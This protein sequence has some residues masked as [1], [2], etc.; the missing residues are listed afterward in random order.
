MA[1]R[2]QFIRHPTAQADA[3]EGKE[4]EI[5]V[6]LDNDEL[7]LHDGITLGGIPIARKDLA[8]VLQASTATD[9]K[10]T[11]SHVV[12][13]TAATLD[14]ANE[15]IR[16]TAAEAA[17]TV[18]WLAGVAQE[19]IDRDAAILVETNARI[20]DVDAEEARALLAEGVLTTA[21]SSEESARVA[22]DLLLI[23]L[24][25]KA[26]ANGVASLTASSKIVQTA[27]LADSAAACTGNAATVTN[28][29]YTSGVQVVAEKTFTDVG[30]I[31]SAGN[32]YL[33]ADSGAYAVLINYDTGTSGCNFYDGTAS[34]VVKASVSASGAALEPALRGTSAVV[35]WL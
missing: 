31:G 8:N 24:T 18:A 13:L 28:G 16:A 32:L 34:G 12:E 19:V 22:A 30:K 10:M 7:R 17:I 29:V 27:L 4:G 11:A 33:N 20:A 25:Q 2:V 1:K 6:D 21:V 14:L 9:G 35:D 5:T 26:A 15:I 23:P 3:F